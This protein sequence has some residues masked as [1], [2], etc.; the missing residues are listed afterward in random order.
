MN[1]NFSIMKLFTPSSSY[2][3]ESVDL[4]IGDFSRQ[5]DEVNVF[6][7]DA[8]GNVFSTLTIP[9][10]PVSIEAYLN[11][12]RETIIPVCSHLTSPTY[13]G[14]MTSPLPSFIPE[15]GR[16]IQTLNQN[17]VKMETSRGLTLLERQLLKLL[18]QEIFNCNEDF[19]ADVNKDFSK[20]PGIFTSGGTMANLTAMWVA[21]RR[22]RQKTESRLAVIGSE[23]MHYSF[24][25]AAALLGVELYRLPVNQQQMVSV[26]RIE[27]Q[28]KECAKEGIAVAAIVAIAGTT[29]FGSIDPLS[30]IGELG[31]RYGVHVH[32]DAA[33]G[34][35]F[36]LSCKH[37][38]LLE[39][40]EM[41]DTVTVDGHKQMLMPVGTGMLF[42]KKPELSRILV[43][44][45]PYAVRKTS[46]D[47]GRFTLEGT[48]PANM[49]YLHACLNLIGKQGYSEL[50]GTALDNVKAMACYIKDNP[51]F[52]LLVEPTIN[53][54]SYRFI[55]QHFRKKTLTM[56]DNQRISQFNCKLQKI[57]RDRGKS[58]VSRSRRKFAQYGNN[59]L[60]FL[61]VVVLNPCVEKEHILFM[62]Q[63]QL[64]IANEIEGN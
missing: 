39:G 38:S 25:K 36:I 41:G 15:I 60:I 62:L 58:F 46:L 14:H 40:L 9:E 27:Q 18:H 48:R 12:I 34:G 51:A 61:R 56:E 35:A 30:E 1:E 44:T 24:D 49:L 26:D 7:K 2:F 31:K 64:D 57:Q 43:H 17:M 11:E 50:F 5:K 21:I 55:P 45:A 8:L 22:A 52:E 53:I 13:L 10:K 37:K 47:Q 42:F 4:C 59:E 33:W 16:L 63:N 20:T 6:N 28:I 3:Q 32:I 19:Y 23:L 29:D 54:L